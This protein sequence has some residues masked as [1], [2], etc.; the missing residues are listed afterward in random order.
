MTL[1]GELDFC[2]SR[3]EPVS[4][5]HAPCLTTARR[6]NPLQVLLA[7]IA[8]PFMAKY[9]DNTCLAGIGRRFTSS[10]V[11]RTARGLLPL[12]AA[13]AARSTRGVCRRK[14]GLSLR[15][16]LKEFK[17]LKQSKQSLEH[18]SGCVNSAAT[19]RS[20]RGRTIRLALPAG[21]GGL[22]L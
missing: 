11:F 12:A 19:A 8:N 6:R 7:R 3:G 5:V 14:L 1:V 21:R 17:P 22:C 2:S 16:R 13:G 20:T 18:C 10:T 15:S 4:T 9:G